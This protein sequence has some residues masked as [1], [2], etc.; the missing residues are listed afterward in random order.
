VARNRGRAFTNVTRARKGWTASRLRCIAY[1]ISL[2]DSTVAK[3]RADLA[4]SGDDSTL[5]MV[6]VTW[7]MARGYLL[8]APDSLKR[9]RADDERTRVR[10]RGPGSRWPPR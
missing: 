10:K 6:D 5:Q 3:V 4:P 9:K 1:A 7:P 8:S 2:I